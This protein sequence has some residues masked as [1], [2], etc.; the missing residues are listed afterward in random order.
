[1]ETATRKVRLSDSRGHTIRWGTA[2]LGQ[3]PTVKL[4]ISTVPAEPIVIQPTHRLIMG[5]S[6]E[7]IT[8]IDIN[9]A[10]YKAAQLGVSRCH[11]ALEVVD[12]TLMISDLNSTN[13]TFL[14]GQRISPSQ[15]RVVR[16][17]DEILLGGPAIHVVYVR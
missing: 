11:A 6:D 2:T 12:K 15:R 13:G 9:L 5:R 3:R 16:D 4:I 7:N 14:N 8:H 17:S 1:M 10:A